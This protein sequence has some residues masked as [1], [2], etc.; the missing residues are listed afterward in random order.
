[1]GYKDRD[2][3]EYLA[4]VDGEDLWLDEFAK[5][6]FEVNCFTCEHLRGVNKCSAYPDG[7]PNDILTGMR[8]HKGIQLDQKGDLVWTK[9]LRKE[10]NK[11]TLLWERES[12]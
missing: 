8:K 6:D 1:M 3:D 7:I 11:Q 9:D 4:I 10:L 5:L 2:N 12:A